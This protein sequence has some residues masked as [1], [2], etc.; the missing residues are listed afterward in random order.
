MG[1]EDQKCGSGRDRALD[2][3]LSQTEVTKMELLRFDANTNTTIL[4]FENL[5]KI[6]NECSF[7]DTI[8]RHIKIPQSGY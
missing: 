5:K 6:D 3:G 1:G 2:L 4:I 8:T 7:N